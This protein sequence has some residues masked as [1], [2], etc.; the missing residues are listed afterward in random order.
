MIASSEDSTIDASRRASNRRACAALSRLPARGDVPEDRARNPRP[1]RRSSLIGAALSSMGRSTPSLPMRIV[2]VR[3]HRRPRRRATPLPPDSRAVFRLCASTIAEYGV[4]RLAPR[5]VVRPAGQRLGDGIEIGDAAFDIGGDDG[6]ADAAERHPHQL[7]A[8]ART[9][10]RRAH[11]LAD[12]DD[13]RAGEDVGDEP[14]EILRRRRG[15]TRR[16]AR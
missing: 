12:P 6:V 8:L 4:E 11:R 9:Q 3:Q 14:D 15:R 2:V 13:Q 16:G 1:R 5:V 7:A 10:L